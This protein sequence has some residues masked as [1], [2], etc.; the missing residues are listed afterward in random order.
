MKQSSPSF[1]VGQS[2]MSSLVARASALYAL[3]LF[4][5]GTLVGQILPINRA[6]AAE[7]P[8]LL[9]WSQVDPSV[10]GVPQPL[11]NGDTLR[12]T[13][14][15]DQDSLDIHADC[16]AISPGRV[17]IE[18]TAPRQ[19]LIIHE[20]PDSNATPDA[21]NL[22]I[23]LLAVNAELDSTLENSPRVCLSNHP[24]RLV[25]AFLV[26]P[27]AAYTRGDSIV[28]ATRWAS[29]DSASLLVTPDFRTIQPAFSPDGAIVTVVGGGNFGDDPDAIYYRI[30]F[31][32]PIRA[33]SED[34]PEG[35]AAD[36]VDLAIPIT[37]LDSG[38]GS[39]TETVIRVNLDTTPPQEIPSLDPL[40][41]ETTADSVQVSGTALGAYQVALFRNDSIQKR[42]PVEV[43]T[44]RFTSWVN[45][46]AD[47]RNKIHVKAEDELGNA[48]AQSVAAFVIQ[49]RSPGLAVPRPYKRD[50]EIVFRSLEPVTGLELRLFDLE[51]SCL[52]VWNPID[53]VRDYRF[54]WDGLDVDGIRGG[55]GMY[56]LRA[57]WRAADG[58]ARTETASLFLRD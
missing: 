53:Q 50:A 35:H 16:R 57:T 43:G 23:S 12:I 1:R 21:T 40:P 56:L 45:L 58:R 11:R 27:P 6:Q 32:V 46:T 52:R 38:C 15:W 47:R 55:Q 26:N 25:R 33:L 18:R 36:G 20:V 30:A 42:V 4:L 24:P 10:L 54:G 5:V 9:S 31:R 2:P 3:C 14:V 37:A 19:Y 29:P 48:G 22:A 39:R 34:N 17:S 49:L 51:G 28:I 13:T 8:L 41:T 7:R 44:G